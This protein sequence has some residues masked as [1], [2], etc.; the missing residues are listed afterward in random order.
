MLSKSINYR[1][2]IDVFNQLSTDESTNSLNE[3]IFSG[4]LDEFYDKFV[5]TCEY[6]KMHCE[7]IE[8]ISG[9]IQNGSITII[10][11]EKN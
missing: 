11:T 1:D 3:E 10:I 8:H 9:A 4:L 7:S 5:E 2:R 6:V